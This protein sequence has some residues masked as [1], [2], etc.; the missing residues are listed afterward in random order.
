MRFDFESFCAND[1]AEEQP[2]HPQVRTGINWEADIPEIC[3]SG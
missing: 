2:V 1:F 3:T